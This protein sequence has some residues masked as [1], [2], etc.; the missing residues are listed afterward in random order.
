MALK[1]SVC[2]KCRIKELGKKSWTSMA[3]AWWGPYKSR[4]EGYTLCPYPILVRIE[5]SIRDKIK[6]YGNPGEKYLMKNWF[7]IRYNGSIPW[8]SKNDPPPWCLYEKEH[9]KR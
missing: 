1:K 7:V 4:K 9:N 6:K 2:K 5:K 3:D 8:L